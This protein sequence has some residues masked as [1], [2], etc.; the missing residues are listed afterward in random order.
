MSGRTQAMFR[1]V[2]AG[3]WSD[4][5]FCSLKDDGK[6][7]WLYLLTGREVT[8]LPGLIVAGRSQLAETMGWTIDRFGTVFASFGSHAE[9]DWAARVVWLPNATKYNKPA[10]PNVVLGWKKLLPLVPECD[11]KTRALLSL[12]RT[13]EQLGKPFAEAFGESLG[14]GFLARARAAPAPA[15]AA[16]RGVQ[17]GPTA[18]AVVGPSEALAR[19]W[20]ERQE[21]SACELPEEAT[22]PDEFRA[23]AE[24]LAIADIDGVFVKFKGKRRSSRVVSWN[25]LENWR[26]WLVDERKYQRRDRERSSGARAVAESTAR[27]SA[28][29]AWTDPDEETRDAG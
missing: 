13:C 14:E 3:T 11:L 27:S 24:E 8:S 17:G 10:N 7:L 12:L 5:W 9:A 23:V 15:T 2:D 20:F 21:I 28:Y 22:L 19:R 16:F 6:L 18:G 4:A 29:D 26:G 25:W 1:K